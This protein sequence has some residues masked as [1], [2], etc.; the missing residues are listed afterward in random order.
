MRLP[1]GPFVLT[2]LSLLSL[3]PEIRAQTDR[4]I[5]ARWS[6]YTEYGQS[7]IY[8]TPLWE[9]TALLHEVTNGFA[10][11]L[12]AEHGYEGR[13][14][15][16]GAL[17]P[18]STAARLTEENA[19]SRAQWRAEG[20][21][22]IETPYTFDPARASLAFACVGFSRVRDGTAYA[23]SIFL[24]P[25]VRIPGNSQRGLTLAW[26]AH[27]E[28]SHPA[29]PIYPGAGCTMLP[30]DPAEHQALIDRMPSAYNAQTP[31]ILRVN[32]TYTPMPGTPVADPSPTP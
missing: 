3:P 21:T 15:C 16:G 18:T 31:A 29:A 1:T 17:L 32:W 27:L 13:I 30:P 4:P 24:S 2:A 14:S 28:E 10:Q 19:R 8:T 25:V 5:E 12:L 9:A 23:D 7:T 20:K 6:C 22:V 26:I 11:F